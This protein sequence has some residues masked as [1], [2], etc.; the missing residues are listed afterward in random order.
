MFVN[1]AL[2]HSRLSDE[3]QGKQHRPHRF[4]YSFIHNKEKVKLKDLNP[5][6]MDLL[7]LQQMVKVKVRMKNTS[8]LNLFCLSCFYEI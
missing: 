4:T 6:L 3:K 7:D 2:I 1:T 5:L 8:K